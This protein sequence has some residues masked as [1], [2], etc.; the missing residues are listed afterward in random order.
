VACQFT[1]QF[2]GDAGDARTN[3]ITV[4]ATAPDGTVVTD[5]ATATVTITDVLP[6]I[7][8]RKDASPSSRPAPGGTFTFQVRV[9]NTGTEGV[10]LTALSDDLHGNLNGR[11]SCDIGGTIGAGATYACAFT[12]EFTGEGGDQATDTVLATVVDDEGNPVTGEDSE[13]IRLTGAVAAVATP[14]PTAGPT[15]TPLAA[16]T[17]I[18]ASPATPIPVAQSPIVRTGADTLGWFAL[19]VALI[20]LGS[21]VQ[22]A[23]PVGEGLRGPRRRR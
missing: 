23:A 11:G 16:V 17:P 19:A 10:V 7:S 15:S 3:T 14:T 6:Q 8:V 9:T 22:R 1:V 12:V 13:T 4:T 5:A 18:P 2:T 20:V 21:L